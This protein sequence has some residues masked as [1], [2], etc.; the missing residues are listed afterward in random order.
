MIPSA[1]PAWLARIPLNAKARD[2]RDA[3][4]EPLTR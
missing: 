1:A 4:L 2:N 3:D